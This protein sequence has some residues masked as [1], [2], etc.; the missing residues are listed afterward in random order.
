MHDFL[1]NITLS[2]Q[3]ASVAFQF[4]RKGYVKVAVDKGDEHDTRMERLIETALEAAAE[5]FEQLE[6]TD[7]PVEVEVNKLQWLTFPDTNALL[8]VYMSTKYFNCSY[9]CSDRP[10]HVS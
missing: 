8:Q 6:H 3:L 4:Q 5:D 10:W 1:V 9:F 2:A 7:G